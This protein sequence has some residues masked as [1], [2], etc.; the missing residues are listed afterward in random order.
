[1]KAKVKQA[2][3]ST[4]SILLVRYLIELGE[5]RV[6]KRYLNQLIESKQLENDSNLG[7]V[8]NCL[9]TIHSR[10]AL[11]GEALEYYRKALNTQ[12]RI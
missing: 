8:Y 1:M 12:A 7:S 9:G 10:Q 3:Q 11:Y 5:D 6:C 4:L 2:S